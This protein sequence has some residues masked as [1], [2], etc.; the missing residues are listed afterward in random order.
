MQQH[1]PLSS[2][3][4]RLGA[5]HTI[6]TQA[7]SYADMPDYLYIPHMCNLHMY[8]AES[9]TLLN[10]GPHQ[11]DISNTVSVHS[12]QHTQSSRSSGSFAGINAVVKETLSP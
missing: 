2:S 5:T 1:Q 7:P 10:T 11:Q 4:P 9:E 12:S 6:P 3:V 8:S